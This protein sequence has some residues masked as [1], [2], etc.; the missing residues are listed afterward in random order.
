MRTAAVIAYLGCIAAVAIFVSQRDASGPPPLVA[1]RALTPNSLVLP[2]DL[3]LADAPPL[4]VVDGRYLGQGPAIAA[5]SAAPAVRFA[6]APDLWPDSKHLLLALPLPDKLDP[7]EA[8]AGREARLC[9]PD[10]AAP[11]AL[12]IRA[13][14]CDEG[15]RACLVVLDLTPEL[16]R[17]AAPALAALQSAAICP[18]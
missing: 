9:H 12:R 4:S 16:A 6:A 1:A 13:L 10:M 3:R 2:G 11:L 15:G 8:N 18:L 5:G 14:R 17:K 7:R